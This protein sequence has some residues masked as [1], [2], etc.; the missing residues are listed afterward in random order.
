MNRYGIT[1]VLSL[2]IGLSISHAQGAEA[3]DTSSK[4]AW[5]TD[6][7]KAMTAADHQNKMMFVYF[8]DCCGD[9]ACQRFEADVLEQPQVREKLNE[10]VCV[11]LPLD[12][13]ITISG[14]KVVLLEHPS[15]QEMLGCSGMAIVDFRTTD[16]QLRGKIASMF[17]ITEKLTYSP[18]QVS[19][20][21]NLPTGTL[22]QRTLIYAVRVHPDR[23]ASTDSE[24]N[25]M[26]LDEAESHSQYQADIRLQGH[27]TWESRFQR[28]LSRLHGGTPREVCDESWPG[29]HLVEAAIECV[30]C[31]RLSSGHWNAVSSP[32]RSFGY[33]MKRGSN[34]IW[35]ATGILGSR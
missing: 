34:G 28:I 10:Y 8:C 18:D 31:W 14:K 4:I 32:S 25:T 15:F 12:A 29:E 35:Y 6:Y 17:P 3:K 21:L 26:L 7:A 2:C 27:H 16:S 20:I 13:K 9:T 22:T 5:Q 19:V 23:P 33:D 30:R 11:R 1:L 24:L